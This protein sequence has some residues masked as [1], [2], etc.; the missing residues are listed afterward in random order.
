LFQTI[1]SVLK[2]GELGITSGRYYVIMFG[3]FAT[4]SAII[5]SIRL[6]HKSNI[7]APILIALSLISILPPVDAFTISKRNQIE[8][9][10]N[11]LEKNNM[12]INDKIVPNA[13]ISEEDRNITIS[14]V[15][16]LGSMDYLKDVSWLQDYSTSYDFE[17]T[18]GFPQYGYSIKE[19]DIWRFYLTDRTP[20]D[21]SDYDFIVEVDLYS[22]GKENSFEIIPLGDSGYY[23]DLEPKD[24]IGDLIIRDNRQ[25]EIIRYSF[26]GIFEHFTDRDTDRYSEISM[27]EAEFTAEN[28][29]AALGIVVKTV[30]LEIGE[31][32]DFQNI[33]AYVMVKLK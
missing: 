11:V 24:G 7:I 12:L 29:N 21:V 3:V 31:K 5:F 1:S 23:I 20:I 30:Y 14:S 32:D 15:R 19:P 33:N 25:N 4:V 22:E 8:R 2:I 28:D 18:F 10:T 6:N 13:D 27:N 9:L 17:K 26:S 16:Y